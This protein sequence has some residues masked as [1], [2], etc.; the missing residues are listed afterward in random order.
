MTPAAS[1]GSGSSLR[2]VARQLVALIDRSPTDALHAVADGLDRVVTALRAATDGSTHDG[3]GPAVSSFAAARDA[4]ADAARSLHAALDHLTADLH[5]LGF[6]APTVPTTPAGPAIPTTADTPPSPPP[7]PD[8]EARRLLTQLP[9]HTPRDKTRG[10]WLDPHGELHHLI[11]GEHDQWHKAANQRA[12]DL[13]LIWPGTMLAI[14]SH[15]EVKF[16]MLMRAR[17]ITQATIVVNKTPCEDRYGCHRQL[18][19]FLPEGTEL[20][21][22]GPEGF[23]HTYYGRGQQ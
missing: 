10:L 4:A 17:H 22:Y 20:T 14:A 23:R 1:E 16:A 3:I 7:D 11:S 5:A 9:P 12:I 15:V 21:V 18:P 8:T 2:D 19:Q 13:G 6:P